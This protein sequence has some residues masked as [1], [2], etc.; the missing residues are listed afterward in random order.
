MLSGIAWQSLLPILYCPNSE[1]TKPKE[2]NEHRDKHHQLRVLRSVVCERWVL[3][4]GATRWSQRTL[5][6]VTTTKRTREGAS[7][8]SNQS[9]QRTYFT[10]VT[11]SSLLTSAKNSNPNMVTTRRRRKSMTAKYLGVRDGVRV[12]DRVGVRDVIRVRILL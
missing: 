5:R 7:V 12:E 6:T 1:R 11:L 9:V 4:N 8:Y 10:V 2:R 3:K